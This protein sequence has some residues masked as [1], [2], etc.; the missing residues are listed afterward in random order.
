MNKV[1][2]NKYVKHLVFCVFPEECSLIANTLKTNY[3]L[4]SLSLEV[5]HSKN[6]DWSLIANALKI[7]ILK[8]LKV[9]SR[10]FRPS[11]SAQGF[12]ILANKLK[13]NNTLKSLNVEENRIGPECAFYVVEMLQKNKTLKSLNI[14]DNNIS[15]DGYIAILRM[16]QTNNILKSLEMGTKD[17][18]EKKM[19]SDKF[20]KKYKQNC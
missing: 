13:T 17:T 8:S 12:A 15:P 5:Y 11:N 14:S 18:Y 6:N 19:Q 9:S 1:M 7:D 3:T 16:L 20:D 10:I 4:K 2:G